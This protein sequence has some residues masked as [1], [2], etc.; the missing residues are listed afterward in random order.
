M[1]S[2]PTFKEKL[3]GEKKEPTAGKQKQPK[4]M[5]KVDT[6]SKAES[7]MKINDKQPKP[8]KPS[9]SSR[10]LDDD[11]DLQEYTDKNS[12]DYGGINDPHSRGRQK[13]ADEDSD[14]SPEERERARTPTRA[15][16]EDYRKP[17]YTENNRVQLQ[18]KNRSV[19]T[20]MGI[21]KFSAMKNSFNND[22]FA[23]ERTPHLKTYV[24]PLRGCRTI[25]GMEFRIEVSYKDQSY[26][27]QFENKTPSYELEDDEAVVDYQ[28]NEQNEHVRK[29]CSNCGNDLYK[30]QCPMACV[31]HFTSLLKI[32]NEYCIHSFRC[33]RAH[34]MNIIGYYVRIPNYVGTVKSF[35]IGAQEGMSDIRYP[36]SIYHII[37]VEA[38]WKLNT[39]G[40]FR[41]MPK[42]S[43]QK[44]VIENLEDYLL[45]FDFVFPP[46]E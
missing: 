21:N 18:Y 28:Q 11:R 35:H 17:Y 3:L 42:H 38:I 12:A 46:Q 23:N 39:D 2:S 44:I 10:H 40:V 37:E 8:K 16:N 26:Q 24:K 7:S 14:G 36:M 27:K 32:S 22:R 9:S 6:L 43:I 29:K 31:Y 1:S 45:D 30:F 33:H 4:G 25:E 34:E 5:E 41:K 20:H 19:G 13:W 15:R